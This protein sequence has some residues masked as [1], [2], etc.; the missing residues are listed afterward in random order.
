MAN[1]LSGLHGHSVQRPVVEELKCASALVPTLLRRM[2]A[3]RVW[4]RDWDLNWKRKCATFNLAQASVS[5]PAKME[6]PVSTLNASAVKA[7]MKEPIAKH[8]FVR[9]LVRMEG[10]V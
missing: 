3:S 6:A 9:F 7:C 8:R 1:T 4:I 2:E 10:L 5:H